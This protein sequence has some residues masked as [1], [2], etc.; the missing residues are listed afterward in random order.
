MT[1]TYIV[2]ALVELHM[3]EMC[4]RSPIGLEDDIFNPTSNSEGI[5]AGAGLVALDILIDDYVDRPINVRAGGS[6][7]NVL[8][9]LSS[10]AWKSFPIARLGEDHVAQIIRADM[11]RWGVDTQMAASRDDGRSPIIVQRNSTDGHSFEFRCPGCDAYFPRFKRPL[12]NRTS[13]YLSNLPKVNAF[14]FDRAVP[15]AITLANKYRSNGALVLFEP[16]KSSNR[17][18]FERAVSASHILKYSNDRD[19]QL[20]KIEEPWLHIETLG[21]RGLRFQF[22]NSSWNEMDAV[23]PELVQDTSGAGDWCSA[24]LLHILSDQWT[25]DTNDISFELVGQGLKFGQVLAAM[26][27]K[28]EG[29]RGAHY[30]WEED[31]LKQTVYR[32]R[33]DNNSKSGSNSRHASA[34]ENSEDQNLTKSLAQSDTSHCVCKTVHAVSTD[35]GK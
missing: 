4:S 30:H 35:T 23:K 11:E 19:I 3:N 33:N 26:N 9:I 34:K 17:D 8:T 2:L 28:Y 18:L 31:K 21:E 24:G 25:G 20:G 1:P 32:S 14:Y 27:C 16:N 7:G 6:C 5:V 29:A 13:K 15:S 22:Q 10:L 12:M